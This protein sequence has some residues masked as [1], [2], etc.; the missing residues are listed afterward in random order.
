[1]EFEQIRKDIEDGR[2]RDRLWIT[3]LYGTLIGVA[4]V[5]ILLAKFL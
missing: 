5:G 4:A 3:K 1:M 2:K